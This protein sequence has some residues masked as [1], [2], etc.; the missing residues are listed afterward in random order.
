MKESD[1]WKNEA[2]QLR[3]NLAADTAAVSAFVQLFEDYIQSGAGP[4]KLPLL[5]LGLHH[6]GM[7]FHKGVRFK[8]GKMML[9]ARL[10]DL[11]EA[12]FPKSRVPK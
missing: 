10:E 6:V 7:R 3:R 2:L 9:K 11:P 5:C 12:I 1:E 4:G 8:T